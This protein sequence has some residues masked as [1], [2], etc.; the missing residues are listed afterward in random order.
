MAKAGALLGVSLIDHV[1]V[2]AGRRWISLRRR[3]A[4]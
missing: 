3:G 2:G 1:I 4:F